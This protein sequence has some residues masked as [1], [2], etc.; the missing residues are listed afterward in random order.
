MLI[1]LEGA[2]AF[3]VSIFAGVEH[4]RCLLNWCLA[5]RHPTHKSPRS[6][7]CVVVLTPPSR[8]QGHRALALQSEGE[9]QRDDEKGNAGSGLREAD[10]SDELLASAGLPLLAEE[11]EELAL[12]VDLQTT[13]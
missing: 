11:V 12:Q 5:R 9:E 2:H 1:R 6:R 8:Q 10:G 3:N 13:D 7:E 4:L